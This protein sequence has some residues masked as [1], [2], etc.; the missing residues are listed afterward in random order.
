[1]KI[2]EIKVNTVRLNKDASDINSLIKN[3]EKKLADMQSNVIQMNQMWEGET[4]N[5]FVKVF[6]DDMNAA[7]TV[8][9]EL[10]AIYSYEVNAK[11]EYDKC[12]VKVADI[13]KSIHV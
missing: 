1:M 4:K 12:E 3:M 6:N 9:K 8:I 11:T 13:I 7:K 2:N 5:A 10:K